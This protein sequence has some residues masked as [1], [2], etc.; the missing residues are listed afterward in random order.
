MKRRPRKLTGRMKPCLHCGAE[1]YV[2]AFR[3]AGSPYERKFCSAK[4]QHTYRTTPEQVAARFWSNTKAD[5]NGCILWARHVHDDG[6]GWCGN[7]GKPDR[8]HRVA[9]KLF[10]GEIPDGMYVLHTCDVRLCVN[11]EHLFLGTVQDNMADKIA[12]GRQAKGETSNVNK[13]TEEQA[14]LVLSLKP[15]H[16]PRKTPGLAKALAAEYNIGVGAIHAIWRG[17]HWKHLQ[18]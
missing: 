8:A 10:R 12:K 18:F 2:S 14:R 7:Q 4:C 11:P 16:Y 13:L 6:Y 5:A 9:W 1:F 15:P 3:D 17:D